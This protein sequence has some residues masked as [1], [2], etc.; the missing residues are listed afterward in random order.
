MNSNALLHKHQFTPLTDIQK[1]AGFPEG[2]IFDTLFAYQKLPYNDEEANLPW[3]LIREEASVDYA[4]SLEV[5]PTK[6]GGLV[7]RLTFRED[8]IPVE[9]AELLLRQYDA[10][11]LD[12][13]ENPQGSCEVAPNIGNELL[14]ITKAEESVL[15]SPVFLLH[16]FVER[17]AEQQP[18]KK[19]LEFATSLEPNS[20]Q[21][22]SWTYNQLNQ[23]SNKVAQLLL[24][25]RVVPG[26]IIAICF[27]KCAEASF[28]IIG[29]LKAG[30]AYVALDPNAPADRLNFIVQDSGAKLILTAGKPGHILN[31][32]LAE[33][34]IS[35]DS[36]NIL[37]GCS[38][39]KPSLSRDIKPEDIA[40]CLYTSGTTGTPKGCLITHDN[41]VQ[42]LL[43]FQRLFA[44][45]WTEDSKYL[46]F[47][48]FHF[49]VSVMEQFFSWSIGICMAS[50]PRD[51]IFQDITVAIQQL[52]ITHLD[53]TPSLAR[54][55][56]PNDVPTL[57]KGAF[58]TG[59]EQLKQEILDVW[60]EHAVIYNGYGPT[61]A[62]IGCTM[63]PRV[64]KNGK[65]AN[66]GPAYVNVG[67]FVLKPGTELPVLRGGVGELCVSG[68]LVGK[69]YLN[70]PDLTAEKFPTLK[71]FNERVYRTGD[72]VRILHDGSFIFLGRADDQVKLRGQRLELS[73]INEVVKKSIDDLD[74]VV[75]LVLKHNTQQKEQLVC[76][77]V[78]TSS[79]DKKENSS[80][81]SIMKDAC[82]SRLPGY[83][84]PT[85]FIPIKA[86]PLNANN[87]ADAKQLAAM[88]NKLSIDELQKLSH[89]NQQYKQWNENE[90]Q[91]LDIIAKALNIDL[92]SLNHSTNI[93]ELGLDSISIIGFSRALQ[94]AGLRKAKIS[95]VKSNPSL[96]GLVK[97]LLSS[98]SPD[99]ARENAYVEAKQRLAAFAQKHV[100]GVCKDLGVESAEVESISPCTPVQ[101]GMIYK[102]LES[103][104]ALYFNK[105]EFHLSDSVDIKKF[106]NAWSCV[107]E[108]LEV[109][110]TK[111]VETDDGFAQAVLRTGHLSWG[112]S[113]FEY[114]SV[115][116]S[117][118]LKMPYTLSLESTSSGNT[119]T[120]QIFHG[121]YDGNSLTMLLQ[122][123]VGEYRK[124]ETI[125]YGPSFRTSLPYGPLAAVPGAREFWTSH[126]RQWKYRPMSTITE[127]SQDVVVTKVIDDLA[128]LEYFR[129]QLGVTPQA[130]IQAAWLSVLQAL[131]SPNLTIGMVTSGRAIDFEGSDEVIGPLF[132]TV[133]FHVKVE[134][135]TTAVSLISKCHEFN[136][137]MQDFQHTHLKNIQKW[138]PARPGQPLFDTLFVFQRPRVEDENF[139]EGVWTQVDDEQ[140]A[141]V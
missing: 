16:E 131:I 91:I 107:M 121:L 58:I 113:A 13:L 71:L 101:E 47:A 38:S 8:L 115:E 126:L 129:K 94:N 64:P 104:Q 93:F 57:C 84:V 92:S 133:P 106:L 37:K 130:V 26:Q 90:M 51:L 140:I 136:M 87:K 32:I 110:R 2:K 11:L 134:S 79:S 103:D 122:R 45:H 19:A 89:S 17:G 55:L 114:E 125:E 44:G 118:A 61:E 123:V 46:Q 20:F 35:L 83:M 80:L 99:Q 33:G 82:K 63:Y 15:P 138:S 30:C 98:N 139:S 124:L 10:L 68:K 127:T 66:I 65:P 1:W 88:Y 50:A 97:A 48:S 21:S 108:R 96:E 74:Q 34:V 41:V 36:P 5:Q 72:L 62:T 119:M 12:T 77:F 60:G 40:Y 39:K 86:L 67:S 109:L 137:K 6:S 70:R 29:I 3:K 116:K 49:D 73:E 102:F 42:F 120:L 22:R 78:T 53:L 100:V 23:E 59:G 52:A 4:V 81:I 56:H 105:F 75:T 85:H 9:H 111:F 25:Q 141:D 27:D 14:S 43:A 135:G 18:D 112:K 132:N 28:A 54:L 69:G 24:Q 7:L 117:A 76:F 128:A 95:V 31:G